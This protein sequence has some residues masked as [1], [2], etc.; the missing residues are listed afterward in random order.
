MSAALFEVEYRDAHNHLLRAFEP[1]PEEVRA[2]AAQL[3]RYYNDAHNRAML[4][5]QCDMS[6][7]EVCEHYRES[8]ER[9]SRL[10]LL[11]RDSVLVGDAD[12]RHFDGDSAEYAVMIGAR[13]LQGRGLG[14]LFTTMLHAWALRG[15]GLDCVYVTIF[16]GNRA[17]VRLFE[18]LG[19]GPDD[20]PRARGLI[21]EE[22]DLTMSVRRSLF[23]HRHRPMMDEV[24]FGARP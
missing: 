24:R 18:R 11:E 21:D 1:S 14:Q 12:F 5:N 20:G 6:A 17:S 23:E 13:D 3:S 2:A 19:Y 10:F 16:P 15:L 4:T 7:R 8:R 9:G 22:G